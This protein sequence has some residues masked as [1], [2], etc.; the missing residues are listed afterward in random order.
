M[1]QLERLAEKLAISE[2]LLSLLDRCA[3]SLGHTTQNT[4]GL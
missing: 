3:I 4:R 1:E 2:R